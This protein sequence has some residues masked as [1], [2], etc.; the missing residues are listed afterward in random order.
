MNFLLLPAMPAEATLS[1]MNRTSA[2]HRAAEHLDSGAFFTTLQRRV[3]F[4]TESQNPDGAATLRAYLSDEMVPVL[5]ALGFQTRELEAPVG[6]GGHRSLFLVAERI[7]AP[8][9]PTVLSYGHGDVVPGMAGQWQPGRDPWT[10]Q[11]EGDR[12]YGRGTAD[13][14]GQHSINLGAIAAVLAE[15]GGRLGFNL[16]LLFEMGEEI[17]SPGLAEFCATHRE[18]LRADL[19]LASDGPRLRADRPTLFLG[20]RGI[21]NFRLEVRLRAQGYHSGNWGGLLR[22]PATTLAGALASVVDGHGAIRVPELRPTSLVDSVRRALAGIDFDWQ[23]GE[24]SIDPSWG[25]PG[26]TPQER[27]FGWN[28]LEVLALQCG[29]PDKPVNAIPPF[30]VAHCQLRFVV[31]TD[32]TNLEAHLRRHL[33]AHGFPMVD[34]K[35]S[36]GAPATRLDPEDPWVQWALRSV[37]RTTHK[38]VDVLPNLGGTLPNEVF[39]ETLGLPTIWVPHSYPGCAQHAPDEHLL[40]PVAREGLQIMAG[41]FWDLGEPDVP[42]SAASASLR[43][44]RA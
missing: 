26:L 39:A 2:L 21:A 5:Q 4:A 38:P 11:A 22:N 17:G 3:A 37:A 13:N 24:P 23:P 7:E 35:V 19:F 14:K 15:R 40:A 6:T 44:A 27:V 41:L 18:A 25:E 9:L 20:S 36:R 32:W 28:S 16:K 12:W 33:D 29:N 43:G 8:H 30:A 42:R 10:L 31:G 1:L 34:V